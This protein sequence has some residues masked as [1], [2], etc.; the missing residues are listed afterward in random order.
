MRN[1]KAVALRAFQLG[2]FAMA[3]GT[4]AAC[5]GGGD[6]GSSTTPANA[7]ATIS[8]TA[9]IGAPMANASITIVCKSGSGAGTANANGAFTVTFVFA[10]PCTIT[11]TNGTVTLHSLASGGGTFNV[12]PLTEL[13]LTYLAAQLGTDLNGLL[14]GL[15]TN[16]TYQAALTD[17]TIVSKA[18]SGVLQ[19]LKTKYGITLSASSFL[20]TPFTPGQA[21]QDADLDHLH[22]AGAFTSNGQPS[23]SLI[24]DVTTAGTAS[25]Q[26]TGGTGGSG[27]SG[28]PV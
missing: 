22:T 7:S 9:A 28:A 8:G 4:L 10:G 15:A 23:T 14:S 2:T 3:A 24:S 6:S 27:G 11:G 21:G 19:V 25:R 5:G 17:S 16:S 18:E 1:L 12:T 26:P 20:T 13:L